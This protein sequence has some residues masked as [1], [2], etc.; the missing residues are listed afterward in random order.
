MYICN[1]AGTYFGILYVG[2]ESYPCITYTYQ[3]IK[4]LGYRR[5]KLV[6]QEGPV[7]SDFTVGMMDHDGSQE[8][9]RKRGR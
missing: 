6:E 8:R 3:T 2:R 9:S 5:D 4:L 7:L 1:T